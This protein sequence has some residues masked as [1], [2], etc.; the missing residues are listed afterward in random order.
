M[1]LVLTLE[2]A[3]VAV[4]HAA[5]CDALGSAGVDELAVA[6]IE[7]H[8]RNVV[9]TAISAAEE[10]EVTRLRAADREG[11]VMVACSRSAGVADAC[12]L[13]NIV[14]EAAAV[15]SGCCCATPFVWDALQTLG[16]G[17]KVRE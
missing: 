17:D 5:D 16:N 7:A 6:E 13:Q 3:P 10:D 14:N 9:R 1:T 11:T 4:V 2:L 8:V 15:K 12:L